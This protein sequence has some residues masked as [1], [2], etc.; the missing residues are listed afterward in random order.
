MVAV[1]AFVVATVVVAL[2]VLRIL[3]FCVAVD[4]STDNCCSTH[5]TSNQLLHFGKSSLSN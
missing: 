2:A 4:V 3:I 5:H 1:D